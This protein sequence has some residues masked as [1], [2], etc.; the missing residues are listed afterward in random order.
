[1]KKAISNR[2]ISWR[3]P[4]TVSVLAVASILLAAGVLSC[5]INQTV[6]HYCDYCLDAGT[7]DDGDAG[8]DTNG[9]AYDSWCDCYYKERK[10]R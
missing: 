4:L 10:Q 5:G 9:L 2:R 1:M 3:A 7:S 8:D 6:V